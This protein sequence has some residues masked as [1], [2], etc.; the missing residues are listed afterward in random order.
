MYDQSVDSSCFAV[1]R[2]SD[3]ESIFECYQVHL[4]PKEDPE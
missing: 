1:Y 3:I 4:G 2:L